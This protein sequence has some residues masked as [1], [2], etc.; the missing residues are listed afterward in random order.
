MDPLG[1]KRAKRD[2][3]IFSPWIQTDSESAASWTTG[4]NMRWVGKLRSFWAENIVGLLSIYSFFSIGPEAATAVIVVV[5]SN[6]EYKRTLL[7]CIHACVTL[8]SS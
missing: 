2:G 1:L 3:V 8:T 5:V 6:N 4:F 7:I